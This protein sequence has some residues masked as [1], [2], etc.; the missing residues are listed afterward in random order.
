MPS[1][2]QLIMLL[3]ASGQDM[4][5]LASAQWPSLRKLD[6]RGS[7]MQHCC[8]LHTMT[9][10]QMLRI[11]YL[12]AC[13]VGAL[14]QLTGLTELHLVQSHKCKGVRLI[15]AAAQSELGSVLA[16][17]TGLKS[18]HIPHAPPGPV[19]H[20]LSQLTALTQLCL[21]RQD[22]VPIVNP[23]P[24][25]LPSVLTCT[26][27]SIVTVQHLACVEAP[28][29]RHLEADMASQPS[30]LAELRRL[31]RGLFTATNSLRFELQNAW[32]K[33][34]TATL[35]EVLHQGWQPSAEALQPPN[36]GLEDSNSSQ[37]LRQWR[38]DLSGATCSRQCLSLLPIG[39]NCL[40]L[41]YV[42][43]DRPACTGYGG[44][45]CLISS[46]WGR[47]QGVAACTPQAAG[48]RDV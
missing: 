21:L 36:S 28:C 32:S 19:T 44:S 5:L 38:L 16:A 4:Q 35:M 12:D 30:D 6:L 33:E 46:V 3:G 15:P 2:T 41:R 23:G 29:L 20:A 7:Q 48:A 37:H 9:C 24:L 13:G 17:L 27:D 14:A 10:L 11:E 18:L 26:F 42:K 39:L 45:C 34:D 25:T 8:L 1:L 43:R 31:C 22:L 40:F 47:G